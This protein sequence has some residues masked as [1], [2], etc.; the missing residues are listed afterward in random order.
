MRKP[1]T[2]GIGVFIMLLMIIGFI[3]KQRYEIIKEHQQRE[4]SSILQVVKQNIEQSLKSSYLATLT[5][6]LTINDQGVPVGF[7]TVAKQ[8]IHLNHSLYAV[9][10]VPGGIIKY[11]YPV[12]GNE[13]A[14]NSNIFKL[15]EHISG[16]AKIAVKSKKMHFAGPITLQQGGI[17]VIGRLPI[18]IDNKF[19]GFSAVVIK[20]NTL[21]KHAG[22]TNQNNYHFQFSKVEMLKGKEVFFL[23]GKR[24]FYDNTYLGAHLSEGNWKLYILA[25]NSN[26]IYIQILPILILGSLLALVLSFLVMLILN[27]PAELQL[28]LQKQATRLFESEVKFKTIFDHAAIGI[29]HVNAETG[30]LLQV[31]RKY[32][33]LLDYSEEELHHMDFQSL[34]Y[35]D[36]LAENVRQNERLRQGL[37]EEFTMQKRILDKGGKVIWINL[38]VSALRITRDSLP[39]NIAIVEDITARKHAEDAAVASQQKVEALINTIDGIVWE[40]DPHDYKFTFVSNKA[41]DILGYPVREWLEQDTFW[42]DH[43]HPEDRDWV[44]SYCHQSAQEGVEY[45]F[46][47]RMISTDGSVVW[48]RDIVNVITQDSKPI[49]LRGIMIDI[50]RHK[51]AEI[52]LNNSFQLITEQNKRLLNFSYIISHNLRSHSSNIQS[53]TALIAIAESDKE[54]DKLI[55]YLKI[56]SENLNDTLYNLNEVVNIQTNMHLVVEPL[57]L[58]IYVDNTI[59]VMKGQI[60]L[61]QAEIKNDVAETVVINYNP[62]YLESVLLN[63]ISNAIKHSHPH[64]LPM[65][66][67]DCIIENEQTV[68]RIS[69]NG[70]GIDLEKNGDKL[71]GMYKTF[72]DHPDSRGIGLFITKNQIEA[73]GGSVKVESVLGAGTTFKIYFK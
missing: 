51:Q 34:S 7:D 20:L 24:D 54:R 59:Q 8:L 15:P 23:P 52:D 3:S 41:A 30:E 66:V 25:S 32:C 39:T 61:K 37:Q 47:Y 63:F 68:L 22:V 35:P 13:K 71:Y 53:I 9:E 16:D 57:N 60:L 70:V 18:Y 38:T 40:S 10:L 44:I 11:I 45:D 36:D 4:M 21:L 6:A 19:W 12:K 28:L 43:I 56:L 5:L 26:M 73:M 62:S 46:E 58:K 64:R 49:A 69:D 27:R 31:N 50:T 55:R 65:V 1:K 14:I 29:A 42:V 33:E 17:G 67:L 48:L 2:V 72:S